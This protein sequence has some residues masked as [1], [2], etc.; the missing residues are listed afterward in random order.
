MLII[1]KTG[2]REA[3][4]IQENVEKWCESRF[5]CKIIYMGKALTGTPGL[6]L[7]TFDFLGTPAFVIDGNLVVLSA[8]AT[9]EKIFTHTPGDMVGTDI[10]HFLAAPG[11]W[12]ADFGDGQEEGWKFD[13]ALR[14]KDGSVMSA[15]VSVMPLESEDANLVIVEDVS[16]QRVLKQRA[17]QRTKELMILSTFSKMLTGSEVVDEILK[18]VI[19]FLPEKMGAEAGWIHLTESDGSLSLLFSKGYDR[20]EFDVAR[21]SPGECLAG[22][23]LSSGR[24]LMV[25]DARTDPRVNRIDTGATGFRTI[26]SVPI[27]SKNRIWGIL[28]LASVRPGHF[29]SMDMQ[30]LSLICGELGVAMENARLVEVLHEKMRYLGLI[31]EL[32]ST[33]NSSL[34][35]GT[36][37]R[38]ML[39]ELKN[40]IEYDRASLLLFDERKKNLLIFA[41]DTEIKTILPKGMRAPLDGTSA[42]W[43]IENNRPWINR[44]LA[45]EIHFV[46][47]AKLRDDGIRS[48]VSIPLYQDKMLGV[49]NLDSSEPG[50]YTEKDLQILLPASKHIAIALENSLLFEEISKEKKEWE[51]T[52]DAITDMVWIEDTSQRVIRANQALLQKTGL[53]I[54][55]VTGT[56]CGELLSLLG[57]GNIGCLCTETVSTKLPSSREVRSEAGGIFNFWAYP[58]IDEEGELYAIVHY[59]KDVTSQRRL[60]QQL[61]RADKLASL[62]T[63]VAGIAHEINNPLG[64]IAGYSE[65]LLNRAKDSKKLLA[66]EEFED[67]PEYLEIIHKEM[68]RCKEIVGSL[69]DFSRPHKG[70]SR[71]LDI[72]ELIK[73][74]IL[75]VNH[76]AKRLHYDLVLDLNRDL[77]KIVAEPG[78]MRQL[79]MN[80]IINSMYFTPEGGRITIKTEM[81]EPR[82]LGRNFLRVRITDTGPGIPQETIDKIFDPFFTTK[83]V[84]EGTGLGLS[85][86]HKIAEEHGGSIEVQNEQGGGTTFIIK[87]PAKAEDD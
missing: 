33:V 14:R 29:S 18:E 23:V 5:W 72:N 11:T 16:G 41:L 19:D 82:D 28:S 3:P 67:F 1:V 87:I 80:I 73:E 26:A 56:K 66:M 50:K 38:I 12:G 25:K 52:F 63:L 31:N 57:F 39:S 34:S 49:F 51:R 43:V 84:G 71:E 10:N 61:I 44:D 36:V 6:I 22:K 74:V 78:S 69:L 20:A 64:I 37:F 7:K 75:I 79:F 54:V 15:R 17:S 53:S 8:N 48:T 62:G 2:S 42:G 68:F 65:A 47:D 24:P 27:I 83:P 86:S 59:L 4:E 21:L 35:I 60:E 40:V 76:R 81:D 13:A 9:A 70:K 77:P 55:E 46:H 85:I 32:S 30:V 58:L 45:S